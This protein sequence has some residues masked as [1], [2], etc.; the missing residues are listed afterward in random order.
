MHAIAL[1]EAARER[2][3]TVLRFGTIDWRRAALLVVDLQNA[4][5]DADSPMSLPTTRA[6]VGN[7]NTIIAAMRESGSSIVFI[8]HTY[9][10]TGSQAMAPWQRDVSPGIA[11]MRACMNPGAW[12][13][14]V[15]ASLNRQSEDLVVDKYRNSAF[16][17]NSSTL[18]E[19]LKARG[20]ETLVIVGAATNICCETTARDAF[21]LGYRVFFIAD[22]TATR[23][24]EEHN[25]AL[26]TLAGYFAD[27]RMTSEFL[28][29]LN[30]PAGA[31]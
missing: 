30:S 20:V 5:V 28:E 4:F 26:L 10:E 6:I 31:S 13:H 23:S 8:R 12:E 19:Q 27:V 15:H 1:P 18:D 21:M 7:V 29:V 2:G 17:Q 11:R 9:T 24:D 3:R 16:I 22:A 25:A 14:D